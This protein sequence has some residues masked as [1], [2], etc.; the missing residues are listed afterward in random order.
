MG[1]G[2]VEGARV[3]NDAD[4]DI[5]ASTPTAL[6]FNSEKYDKDTIH[7]TS[8][9]TDRLTIKTPGIYL[10]GGQVDWE[11]SAV[12]DRHVNIVLN[13]T[14]II[15]GVSKDANASSI[16]EMP[17]VCTV[18]ELIVGDYVQ[19]VVDHTSAV[20]PLAVLARNEESPIFWIQRVG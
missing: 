7:S 2:Y 5:S 16:T 12:G 18:Y 8:T 9:N 6:T 13:G 17:V 10:I 15:A 3:Y 19:L 1:V 14:T 20:D 4:I 11:T